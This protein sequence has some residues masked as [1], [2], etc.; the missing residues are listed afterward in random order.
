MKLS[1][2]KMFPGERV[3]LIWFQNLAITQNALNDKYNVK[4][5]QGPQFNLRKVG[6]K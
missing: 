2:W 1:S 4:R 6:K 5:L 3:H